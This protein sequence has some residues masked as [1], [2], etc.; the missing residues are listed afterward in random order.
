MAK[1]YEVPEFNPSVL[2]PMCREH[3]NVFEGEGVI[4]GGNGPYTMCDK[5]GMIVTKSFGEKPE[6]DIIEGEFTEV[7][8]HDAEKDKD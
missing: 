2:C 7:D 6:P 4:G 1:E 5:C 3:S 8:S